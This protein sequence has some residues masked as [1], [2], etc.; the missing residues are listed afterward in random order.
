MQRFS[1]KI[2]SD[3]RL[4]L[5]HEEFHRDNRNKVDGRQAKC[6]ECKHIYQMNRK[7]LK[8]VYDAKYREKNKEHLKVISGE[9]RKTDKYKRMHYLSNKKYR[10]NNPDKY[11]AHKKVN[12]AKISGKLIPSLCK[13][14]SDKVHAHH[15][16]YSK[17]LDVEWLCSPCHKFL[18]RTVN[19]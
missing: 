18:H 5:S 7:E 12:I 10:E 8:S 15:H 4:Y 1:L 2:C 13:C 9:Y 3:C 14:G 16:D 19:V 11:S 6:K 17:P